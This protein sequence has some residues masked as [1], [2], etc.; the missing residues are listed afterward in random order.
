MSVIK[1]LLFGS[2]GIHY[3][4]GIPTMFRNEKD[5]TLVDRVFK[6]ISQENI[7]TIAH[8]LGHSLACRVIT[9]KNPKLIII[10]GRGGKTRRI[11]RQLSHI[12][13][14]IITTAGPMA[15]MSFGICHF[16]T[17]C[18]LSRYLISTAVDLELGSLLP[19]LSV[20][21][22]L[23]PGMYSI[24]SEI[25]YTLNPTYGDYYNMTTY[26]KFH[27][28]VARSIIWAQFA[29]FLYAVTYLL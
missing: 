8:E 5:T 23:L 3:I 10:E 18:L 25:L 27:S 17:G 13:E 16:I 2:E 12:E 29:F 11:G 15:G 1:S 7:H 24:V 4:F 20:I 26:N 19:L 28:M 14:S 6:A 9:K 21:P 22:L